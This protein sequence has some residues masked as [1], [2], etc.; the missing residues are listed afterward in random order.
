MFLLFENSKRETFP[1]SGDDSG[2]W[3]LLSGVAVSG[4]LL[5]HHNVIV[6]AVGSVIVGGSIGGQSVVGRNNDSF[7]SSFEGT[8]GLLK[9]G[10][11]VLFCA[12]TFH[13]AGDVGPEVGFE[14]IFDVFL[15][16]EEVLFLVVE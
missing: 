16:K 4:V 12:A 15:G 3:R 14:G 11:G 7:P 9:K 8:E 10:D 5:F 2:A 13:I 1:W 6:G